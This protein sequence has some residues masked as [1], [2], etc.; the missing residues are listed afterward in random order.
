MVSAAGTASRIARWT[1]SPPTPESK[2]PMRGTAPEFNAKW[3][4]ARGAGTARAA[5]R[6]EE[7][8]DRPPPPLVAERRVRRD[9]VEV[10]VPPERGGVVAEV[11]ERLPTAVR[12]DRGGG[13]VEVRGGPRE[14]LQPDDVVVAIEGV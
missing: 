2:M 6:R 1:V 11:V 12:R 9:V 14:A 10:D 7:P 5:A 13:A 4:R 3:A 8:P